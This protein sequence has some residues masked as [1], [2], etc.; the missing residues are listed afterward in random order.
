MRAEII[1]KQYKKRRKKMG[2]SAAVFDICN[3]FG[4]D[5]YEVFAACNFNWTHISTLDNGSQKS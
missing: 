4:L 5:Q 2:W 1:L 3:T